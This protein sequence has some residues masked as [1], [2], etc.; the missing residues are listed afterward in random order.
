MDDAA[1]DEAATEEPEESE[2][3]EESEALPTSVFENDFDVSSG[4]VQHFED[5]MDLW[6]V[7]V[8]R[9]SNVF[10]I[11]C[12]TCEKQLVN[13]R[14]NDLAVI[15]EVK[16]MMRFEPGYWLDDACL[17]MY[18]A[19][20]R[21]RNRR[22]NNGTQTVHFFQPAFLP[23]LAHNGVC[24]YG[25]V[26]R[27]TRGVNIFTMTHAVVVDNP[28]LVHWVPVVID[29]KAKTITYM[30]SLG[31]HRAGG[32]VPAEAKATMEILRLYLRDEYARIHGTPMPDAW[33]N[34]G[35]IRAGTCE[36]QSNS[37]DCGVFTAMVMHSLAVQGNVRG[38][39]ASDAPK[40]RVRM[41]T[42][43][44]GIVKGD[45]LDG[46]EDE[47]DEEYDGRESDDD[48]V[49][50]G[51]PVHAVEAEV[52]ADVQDQDPIHHNENKLAKHVQ[53][54]T[55]VCHRRDQQLPALIGGRRNAVRLCR[56]S[57][58]EWSTRTTLV[59]D[60][61][62]VVDLHDQ[63][64]IHNVKKLVNNM[65][66]PTRALAFTARYIATLNHVDLVR[67]NTVAGTL[68]LQVRDT[69][70]KDRQNWV[71]TQHVISR[72]VRVEME[73]MEDPQVDG[74]RMMGTRKYLEMCWKYTHM[75]YSKTLS[76]VKRVGYAIY[77]IHFLRLWRMYIYGTKGLTLGRNFLTRETFQDTILSCHCFIN[78]V[79][80][81]RDFSGNTAI[82]LKK[83]GSD[84]CENHFSTQGSWVQNKRNYNATTMQNCAQKENWL[85][86]L[87]VDPDGPTWA[88][89]NI[90]K[91]VWDGEDEEQGGDFDGVVP[92]DLTDVVIKDLWTSEFENA[93]SVLEE[94]GMGPPPPPAEKKKKKSGPNAPAVSKT[95]SN[96]W[97]LSPI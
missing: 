78:T 43:L 84:C 94:M 56:R 75:Y 2:E 20:L 97:W 1:M 83:L 87:K 23:K 93:R 40:M 5:S 33:F 82:D 54:A 70:R 14:I 27:W 39:L 63:D 37:C 91:C 62:M 4:D 21:F 31:A 74:E 29:M 34:G 55:S 92:P 73:R 17:G 81:M 85:S 16:N 66:V 76:M 50:A 52:K 9:A 57:S 45:L 7:C 32:K 3:S 96:H 12:K 88:R 25:A 11:R 18:R 6:R 13:T 60:K 59:P 24:D 36:Q 51:N 49:E 68:S 8:C 48:A 42:D 71:S 26:S 19:H 89:S 41:F 80:K 22:A 61:E 44:T 69:Q 10:G 58:L 28:D 67:L 95:N 64:Y 53:V 90:H 15:I 65:H 77:V 47:E 38:Y 79:R 86:Y 46:K 35:S 30:D 72:H